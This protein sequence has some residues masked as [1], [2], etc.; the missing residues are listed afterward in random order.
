VQITPQKPILAG[1]SSRVAAASNGV[2]G[3]ER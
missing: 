2:E 1:K 3:N